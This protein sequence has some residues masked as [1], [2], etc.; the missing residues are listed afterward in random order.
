M[1]TYNKKGWTEDQL[2]QLTAREVNNAFG[3]QNEIWSGRSKFMTD[4]LRLTFLAPDFLESRAKFVGQ[5]LRP[6]GKEQQRALLRQAVFM[7]AGARVLN[8]LTNDG[9]AKWDATDAFAWHVKGHKVS[10]RSVITDAIFAA[11]DPGGFIATRGALVPRAFGEAYH[12]LK[13]PKFMKAKGS[14]VEAAIRG[15]AP[16]ML[17]GLLSGLWKKY[18]EGNEKEDVAFDTFKSIIEST[19][20]AHIQEPPKARGGTSLKLSTTLRLR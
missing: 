9:D 7:Y 11:T 3:M 14:M 12:E 15:Q 2:H 5:A 19:F 4:L 10:I 16:I 17:Q 1:E 20:G 6:G 13:Q 18:V 8:A